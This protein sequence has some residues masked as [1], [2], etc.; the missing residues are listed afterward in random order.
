[1]P[2]RRP[3]QPWRLVTSYCTDDPKHQ[4]TYTEL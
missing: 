4:M 2:V 1:M 3:H